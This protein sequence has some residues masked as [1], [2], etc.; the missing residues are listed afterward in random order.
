MRC[1]EHDVTEAT[2]FVP[3]DGVESW[4][5]RLADPIKHWKAGRSAMMLAS[6][7]EDAAGFPPEV[8]AAL[9]PM[10]PGLRF[11]A[12]FPEHKTPL[13]GGN[14]A[15]QT[16]VLV[17]A[18]TEDGLLVIAVEGKV[19]EGFDRPVSE[20]LGAD[21]SPGKRERLDY[22]VGLLGLDTDDGSG[23]PYQLIHRT[24]A[25][26]IEAEPYGATPMMLVHSWGGADEGIDDFRRFT[27][28]LGAGSGPGPSRGTLPDGQPIWF[29]WVRGDER[30][31]SGS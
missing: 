12:G 5:L 31:R 10:A 15:S 18:A 29:A 9:R 26:V 20:W 25:A 4:R 2:F 23:V 13:P 28:L 19:D 1:G 30:W 24:A 6:C 14:R 27:A 3:T 7:W 22:L 16:D 8:D 11:V 17:H 21:P